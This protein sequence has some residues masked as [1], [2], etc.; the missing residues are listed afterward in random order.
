MLAEEVEC[1]KYES[2]DIISGDKLEDTV[3]DDNSFLHTSFE[4]LCCERFFA[5]PKSSLGWKCLDSL[6]GDSQNSFGD[7]GFKR[8]KKVNEG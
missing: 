1:G 8:P 6:I 2:A 3:G 5:I 4:S 7:N